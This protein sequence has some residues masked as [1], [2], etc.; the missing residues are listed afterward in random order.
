VT[1][2]RKKPD[3]W[4]WRTVTIARYSDMLRN[5]LRLVILTTRQEILSEGVLVLH[6]N[7]SLYPAA[8]TG[9]K[10]S[11]IKLWSSW[12]PSVEPRLYTSAFPSVLNPKVGYLS[13]S[14]CRWWRGE[15]NG[16]W[17]ASHSNKTVFSWCCQNCALRCRE[18]IRESDAPV[19]FHAKF[20]CIYYSCLF[21]YWSICGLVTYYND[22]NIL[23]K[24]VKKKC[25]HS[26]GNEFCMN[27]ET[28]KTRE[29]IWE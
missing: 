7:T 2:S 18:T 10:P 24:K 26:F 9:G 16:A 23:F 15:G 17:M 4:F 12:P 3:P 28:R 27:T 1:A 5:E 14:I 22:R 29:V 11:A 20:W 25:I 13:S 8:R 6:D 21:H 19:A